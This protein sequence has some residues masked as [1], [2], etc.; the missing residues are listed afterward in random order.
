MRFFRF[1]FILLFLGISF[2]TNAQ[3]FGYIDSQMIIEKLPEYR[4]AQTEIDQLTKT[5]VAEVDRMKKEV[6]DLREKYKTEEVLLTQEMRDERMKEIEAKDKE[7]REFQNQVF[8]YEGLLFLKRQELVKPIQD[9]IAK[10]AE[11]VA[12]KKKLNFLF[13]KAAD[14]VMIYSDPR[15]NYTDYVLEELGFG[16]PSDTPR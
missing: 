6:A 9:K 8:G 5:W 13:D 4:E 11:K 15:H 16:D 1:S 7:L 3:R 12:R 14:I 2:G 10:A